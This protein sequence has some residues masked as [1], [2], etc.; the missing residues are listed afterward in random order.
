MGRLYLIYDGCYIVFDFGTLIQTHQSECLNVCAK[1]ADR[2]AV[3]CCT[4][5]LHFM[6]FL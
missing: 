6:V 4:L 5:T 3:A 1:Y 2:C